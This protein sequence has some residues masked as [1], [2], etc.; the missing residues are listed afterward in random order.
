MEVQEIYQE[1]TVDP[2]V[3]SV[4]DGAPPQS[5]VQDQAQDT[6]NSLQYLTNETGEEAEYSL[7]A[8]E[9]AY[10]SSDNSREDKENFLL[11]FAQEESYICSNNSKDKTEG[12]SLDLRQER[13]YLFSNNSREKAKYLDLS[14]TLTVVSSSMPNIRFL[15]SSIASLLGSISNLDVRLTK[16]ISSIVYTTSSML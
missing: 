1:S 2:E 14:L 11:D 9:G 13:D 16:P 5:V 3:D 10:I 8:L 6:G 4:P 15:L 12:S 7:L